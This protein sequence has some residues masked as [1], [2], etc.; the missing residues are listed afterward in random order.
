LDHKEPLYR[1]VNTR[2]HG[3]HCHGGGEYRWTRGSK[4]AEVDQP[5]IGSMHAKTLHGLDY[6]PLFKFL[7]SR[8]GRN[9]NETY[10]D[11]VKRLDRD[12]PIF[13]LVARSEKDRQ[14]VVRA[15][16]NAY[17]SGMYVDDN[18]H[19]ALV[20]P[21]LKLEDM[22]PSCACCTHTLNGKPFTRKYNA[23]STSVGGG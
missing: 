9:W 5:T 19:L 2:T 23:E 8:I 22:K 14:E 6:T 3:V 18:G 4:A 11:A 21:D 20:N 10:S 1:K 7:L 13:W 15:G 17:F 12:E 16:E